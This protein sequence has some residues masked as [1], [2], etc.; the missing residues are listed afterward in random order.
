MVVVLPQLLARGNWSACVPVRRGRGMKMRQLQR[1]LPHV[2]VVVP[3]M[4]PSVPRMQIAGEIH[5]NLKRL[6]ARQCCC[7]VVAAAPHGMHASG[8][9]RTSLLSIVVEVDAPQS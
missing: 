1:P 8:S 2:V 7:W 3:V 9:R 5:P 6:V 4:M